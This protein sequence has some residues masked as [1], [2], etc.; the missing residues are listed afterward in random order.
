M[1]AIQ[2]GVLGPSVPQ[3]VEMGIAAVVVLAP[4]PLRSVEERTA[5]DWDL[6]RKIRTV[7]MV[8]VQVCGFFP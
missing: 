5:R 4:I 2:N 7:I 1:V 8:T 6:T 3:L